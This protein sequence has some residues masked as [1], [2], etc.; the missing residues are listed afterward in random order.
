MIVPV[1]KYGRLQVRMKV[2]SKQ[3]KCAF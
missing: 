2:H 3:Q 1:L